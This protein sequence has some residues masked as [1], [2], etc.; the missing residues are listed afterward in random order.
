MK[1][2]FVNALAVGGAARGALRLL[3]SVRSEGVDASLLVQQ[4]D[5]DDGRVLGPKTRLE[6]VMRYV[7]PVLESAWVRLRAPG[8]KTL[9][10]AAMVPDFVAARAAELKPDVIHLHWVG[11]GMLRIETLRRLGRPIV[12]TLHDSWAF[13]GGCHVPFDAAAARPCARHR[14]ACG[15]CPVLGSSREDDLSRSVW[16]RKRRAWHG[17]DLTVI[18]PSRWLAECAA[19]SSLLGS[20]R[21]EHIANGLDLPRFGGVD[22]QTA[23]E[24]LAL[25]PNKKLILFGAQCATSDPNKGFHLLTAALHALAAKGMHEAIELV[26]FGAGEPASVVALPCKATYLGWVD[27]EITLKLLYAAADLIVLPSLLENLPFTVMEAMASGTPAVAF[28]EGGIPD[29]IDH[30]ENGYLARP[31]DPADLADGIAWI[32][33]DD[34]RRE[35][36]SA[37]AREKT[38]R[39][40]DARI[41]ARRYVQLYASLM[42]A[43]ADRHKARMR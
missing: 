15:Q 5:G 30:Q 7:A 26:V 40:F 27:D 25:A 2:L 6:R 10:S 4:W 37:R 29:L 23:R 17:L 22:R 28:R 34:A 24:A 3:D 18:A 14:I 11:F 33:A 20:C 38:E 39:E 13:T 21:I 41:A 32:L 36:L 31:Y 19:S 1:V 35:R 9:F 42:S 8:T 43:R 12:W 16:R